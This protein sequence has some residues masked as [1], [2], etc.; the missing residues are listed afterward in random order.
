LSAHYDHG[1]HIESGLTIPGSTS[2][3]VR[4]FFRLW[5]CITPKHWYE[6]LPPY[7]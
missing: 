3:G 7:P 2:D 6:A 5:I 4:K 1:T